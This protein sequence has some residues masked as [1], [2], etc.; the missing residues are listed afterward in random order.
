MPKQVKKFGNTKCQEIPLEVWEILSNGQKNEICSKCS[1][2]CSNY[3]LR[4]KNMK[5]VK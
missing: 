2:K 3:I 1:F 4:T 5:E